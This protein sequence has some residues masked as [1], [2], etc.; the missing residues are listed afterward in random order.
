MFETCSLSIEKKVLIEAECIKWYSAE[1]KTAKRIMRHVENKY[2]QDKTNELKHIEHRR[3]R[4]F[5]CESVTR[6]IALYNKNKVNECE[7]DSPEIYDQ[8]NILKT[9]MRTLTY[10]LVESCLFHYQTILRIFSL[11]K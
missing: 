7:N 4:Q 11:I 3:L 10:Y 5:E 6:S 9:K 2:N 1:I 8:L